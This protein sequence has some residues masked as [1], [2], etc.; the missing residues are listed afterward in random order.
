MARRHRL[1]FAERLRLALHRSYAFEASTND[2]KPLFVSVS[3]QQWFEDGVMHTE[4]DN[5]HEGLMLLFHEGRIKVA[6][7]AR[8]AKKGDELGPSDFNFI[9]LDEANARQKAI[10]ANTIADVEQPLRDLETLIARRDNNESSYQDLF[11]RYPWILGAE[12][13]AAF[14]HQALD[15][16]N[17]PDFLARRS[18]DGRHDIVEIKPPFLEINRRDGTPN[19]TCQ[20]AIAQSERYLD[21]ARNNTHYLAQRR[22]AFDAPKCW[23]IAGYDVTDDVLDE[24]KRKQRLNPALHILTYNDLLAYVH[25]TVELIKHLRDGAL[26]IVAAE[27]SSS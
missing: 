27:P 7:A 23:L 25:Q 15:D 12:Y 18:R 13:V 24:F 4:G 8:D 2:G 5:P 11:E 17:V 1:A 6:T 10:G 19:A 21:F 26:T 22:L 14:R 9:E 16:K 3:A 20:E